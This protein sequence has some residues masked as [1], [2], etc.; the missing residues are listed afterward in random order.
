[1]AKRKR[2][3]EAGWLKC[4]DWRVMLDYL[5]GKGSDRKFR[6][7][8]CA[9]CRRIWHLLTDRRSRGAVE[10]AERFADRLTGREQVVEAVCRL[11][12][13]RRG[14]NSREAAER[15]ADRLV[16]EEDLTEAEYAAE[17][18][19]EDNDMARAARLVLGDYAWGVALEVGYVVN[20][21]NGPM[22]SELL[23][24]FLRE[25]FGNP[26][27]PVTADPAWLRWNEAA[28]V[29]LAETIYDECAFDRLL[30]LG[31]ALE[32]AGCAEPA[33]LEHCRRPGP[34]ARGCWA[35]DLLL[36]RQ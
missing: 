32:E 28:A 22:P 27:R 5:E 35:V 24:D 36:G 17:A 13:D 15:F 4:T 7:F 20:E 9:C 26:F 11:L 14:Q 23:C 31:D 29:H 1:M 25:I 34:H 6:L 3:T 12:T 8:A 33:I 30:V 21:D 19:D 16:R 10:L 2:M 18:A